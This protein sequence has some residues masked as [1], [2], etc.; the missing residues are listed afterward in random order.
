MKYEKPE[1]TCLGS[2]VAR[3]QSSQKAPLAQVDSQ[4]EESISAY[5]ADE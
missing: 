3:I 2:A 5:E 4:H 1:V